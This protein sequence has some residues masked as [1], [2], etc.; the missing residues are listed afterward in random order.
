MKTVLGHVLDAI[1][2]TNHAID[3]IRATALQGDAQ[4]NDVIRHELQAAQSA[5]HVARDNLKSVRT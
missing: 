3:G 1:E 2:M 5:L 4:G